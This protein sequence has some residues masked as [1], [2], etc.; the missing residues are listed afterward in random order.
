MPIEEGL[1]SVSPC[2][3]ESPRVGRAAPGRFTRVPRAPLFEHALYNSAV[4][5]HDVVCGY[6]ALRRRETLQRRL[7]TLHSGVMQHD[8][9]GRAI[10][11]ARGE[12]LRRWDVGDD[13]RI[14][15][16]NGLQQGH[17]PKHTGT[18]KLGPGIIHRRRSKK[19]AWRKHLVLRLHALKKTKA[20][21]WRQAGVLNFACGCFR[22]VRNAHIS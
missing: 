8:H 22:V 5:E 3:D 12:I 2:Q 10:I 15:L 6:L 17:G 9:V 14:R 1:M 20:Q 18:W 4:F 19:Q 7:A 11:L 16:K 21:Y 13:E